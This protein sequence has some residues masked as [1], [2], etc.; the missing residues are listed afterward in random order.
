MNDDVDD[1]IAHGVRD[2]QPLARFEEPPGGAR[3]LPEQRVVTVE[4]FQEDARNGACRGVEALGAGRIGW[5]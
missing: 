5:Q 3:A 1:L 4:A 2:A